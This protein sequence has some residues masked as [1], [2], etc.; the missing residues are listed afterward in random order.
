M[1]AYACCYYCVSFCLIVDFFDDCL[2]LYGFAVFVIAESVFLFPACDLFEPVLAVFVFNLFCEFRQNDLCVADDGNVDVD[3]LCDA[4]RVDIY[5]D[6][7][8]FWCESFNYAGDTVLKSF[9]DCYEQFREMLAD[10][11]V[12][13]VAGKV[14]TSRDRVQFIVEKLMV[15]EE[16]PVKDAGVVHIRISD[17]NP[18]ED[19]LYHL[20]AFLFERQGGCPVHL[21]INGDGGSQEIVVRASEQL[22]V[23]SQPE[24]IE[25]IQKH[26]QVA[27]VWRE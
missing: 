1:L 26:P 25:E 9:A 2:G 3:V 15:P 5:M 4:G 6:N 22:T 24:T 18:S 8:G 11:T 23:S 27:E 7:F 12:V 16:L 20:R 10:E 17:P 21:H 14:D 19:D 13:G